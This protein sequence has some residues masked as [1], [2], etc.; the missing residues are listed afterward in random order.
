[1]Y[2]RRVNGLNHNYSISQLDIRDPAAVKLA[3]DKIEQELGLPSVVINNA[4]GNGMADMGLW[5]D[6]RHRHGTLVEISLDL[7][8]TLGSAVIG[9]LRQGSDWFVDIE[10]WLK[11]FDFF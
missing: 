7:R 8:Q 1:M 10:L 2:C 5:L 11:A 9:W 6:C 3:V 4:A